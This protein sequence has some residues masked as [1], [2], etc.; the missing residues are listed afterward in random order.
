[1]FLQLIEEDPEWKYSKCRCFFSI[2]LHLGFFGC[3]LAAILIASVGNSESGAVPACAVLAFLCWI[4]NL[5]ESCCSVTFCDADEAIDKVSFK[6]S[7]EKRRAN[8]P[9][10]VWKVKCYHYERRDQL[11]TDGNSGNSQRR[12]ETYEARI[13]THVL[14]R[15]FQINNWRDISSVPPDFG[16]AELM[17]VCVFILLL[18]CFIFM[19]SNF[20]F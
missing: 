1:M 14:E 15:D 11:V 7:I 13:D 3:L 19:K 20:H 6:N 4:L 8:S 18:L 12:L 2:L 9:K 17:E 16:D 10:L 5:I